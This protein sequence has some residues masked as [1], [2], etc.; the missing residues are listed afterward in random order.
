MLRSSGD[1]PLGREPTGGFRQ[2]Y[3]V[4]MK[5]HALQAPHPQRQ[6]RPLVLQVPEL[7]LTRATTPVGLAAAV[8]LAGNQRVQPVGLDP[9]EAG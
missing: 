8:G 4:H 6:H 9:P 1:G 3:E 5:P 7:P 2:D